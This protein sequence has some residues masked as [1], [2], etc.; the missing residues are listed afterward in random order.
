LFLVAGCGTFGGANLVPGQSSAA[1]VQV[2]MGTPAEKTT[3]A[4][5]EAV[6]FYPSAPNGRTTRAVRMRPDGAVVAVEQRL[7]RQYW[8]QIVP[9]RTTTKEVRELLGPPA[10]SDHAPPPTGDPSRK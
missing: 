7:T 9:D 4:A 6:W 1:D 10:A 5:G 3:N 8:S 2:A